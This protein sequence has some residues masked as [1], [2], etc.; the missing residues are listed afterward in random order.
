MHL[1]KDDAKRKSRYAGQ[2]VPSLLLASWSTNPSLIALT[3]AQPNASKVQ[4]ALQSGGFLNVQINDPQGLLDST[5]ASSGA[6]LFVGAR[7]LGGGLAQPGLKSKTTAGRTY[8]IL[9]PYDTPVNLWILNK[10]FALK[11]ASGNSLTTSVITIPAQYN[12]KGT[13]APIVLTVTGTH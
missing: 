2:A 3:A 5:E 6:V 12:S 1:R 13:N 4:T 11:D 8:Q 9:V 7:S 10:S